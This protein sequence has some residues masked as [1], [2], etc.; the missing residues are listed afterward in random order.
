[1]DKQK[2]KQWFNEHF[3][4]TSINVGSQLLLSLAIF[5]EETR[6]HLYLLYSSMASC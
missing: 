6:P 4:T 1:M 3:D 2:T 5:A